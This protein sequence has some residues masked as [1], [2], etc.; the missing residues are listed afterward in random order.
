MGKI[1][2]KYLILEI[3]KFHGYPIISIEKLFKLSRTHRLMVTKDFKIF[4][5]QIPR[6]VFKVNNVSKLL[7]PLVLNYTL[8]I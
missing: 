5:S 3:F 4:D 6:E 8:R 2:G 7:S 1:V